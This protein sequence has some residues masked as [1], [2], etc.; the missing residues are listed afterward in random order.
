MTESTPGDVRR[1]FAESFAV[2]DIAEP[3]VS[4]DAEASAEHVR[5]VARARDFDIVL[6][7]AGEVPDSD[8]E[9][10]ERLAEFVIRA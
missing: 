5:A 6:A 10:I 8:R 3:L 4:F 9:T 2:R 1:M 7:H